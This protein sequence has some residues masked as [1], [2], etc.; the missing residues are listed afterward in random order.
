MT[1]RRRIL[2]DRLLAVPLAVLLNSLVRLLGQILRRNHSIE[3]ATTREI[4][5]CKLVGM[6]S[7]LQATPLLRVSELPKTTKATPQAHWTG[8]DQS[9]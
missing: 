9:R 3:P 8:S 7:I 1:F 2:F 6:G 4:V 5:V